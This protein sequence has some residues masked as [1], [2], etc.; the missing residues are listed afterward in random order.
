MAK[1]T[2]MVKRSIPAAVIVAACVI[3][4]DSLPAS[5]SSGTWRVMTTPGTVGAQVAVSCSGSSAC[6]AVGSHAAGSP[7]AMRWNGSTWSA[8]PV[9]S[10]AASLNGVSCVAA[11][12]CMAVGQTTGQRA[13]AWLWN[14]STWAARTA[15]NPKSTDNTLNAIR[16][17]AKTSC[18]AVGS[19][20]NISSGSLITYP[21]AEFWNGRAWTRQ[22]TYGAPTGSLASVSC[23]SAST[24][25]AVGANTHSGETLAMGLSGS[26]WKTQTTPK[27]LNEYGSPPGGYGWSDTSVSCWSSGCTAVGNQAYCVCSPESSGTV[28]FAERW[29]GS[30]WTLQGKVASGDPLGDG[31]I[32]NPLGT[33]WWNAVHCQSADSCTA[34]GYWTNDNE[35]QSPWT[36]VSAW[37]GTAWSQVTSPSGSDTS[38]GSSLN[39]IACTSGGSVCTAVGGQ[40]QPSA[41]ILPQVTL[42]PCGSTNEFGCAALAE[43]N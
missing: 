32:A 38:P 1:M 17:A 22:S 6:V 37:N 12:Y 25:E 42:N 2:Y 19:H 18:E 16:C 8:L 5:A 9:P 3:M 30:K 34:V 43:R 29:N 39:G 24:C 41:A 13:G 14:G 40:P 28:V 10:L 21:L 36:L 20:G 23:E 7:S 31:G 33:A 35:A 15:Y 27:L 26:T 4:A 11:T